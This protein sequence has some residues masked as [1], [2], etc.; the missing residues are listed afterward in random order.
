[1]ATSERLSRNFRREEFA[2]HCGCGADT[3]DAALIEGLQTL[4]DITGKSIH[5]N[6]GCRCR[7]HNEAIG[8]S[9]QSQHLLGKAADIVV[10]GYPP[11]LVAGIAETLPQFSGSGIGVYKTFTHLDVRST[12]RSRWSQ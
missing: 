7:K 4:R 3:V 5:I 6:S 9:P 2:C 10:D 8:G 1:M 12:G 11:S